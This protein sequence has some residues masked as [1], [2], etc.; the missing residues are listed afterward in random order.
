MYLD[1]D[2]VKLKKRN[3]SLFCPTIRCT[4]A[5]GHL[6]DLNKKLR[7]FDLKISLANKITRALDD[8]A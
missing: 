6:D 4:P 2:N 7:I 8:D 5:C 3:C 1:K